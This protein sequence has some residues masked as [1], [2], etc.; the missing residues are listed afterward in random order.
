MDQKNQSEQN[1]RILERLSPMNKSICLECNI[2]FK[3]RNYFNNLYCE[4]C[5]VVMDAKK[6][7]ESRLYEIQRLDKL[8]KQQIPLKYQ[9]LKY[10][11]TPHNL[12]EL[13]N[14]SLFITGAV[15]VGK[16]TLA[17]CI[18]KT[19][20]QKIRDDCNMWVSFPYLIMKLQGMFR[21]DGNPFEYAERIS[22]TEGLLVIDD[23]GAEKMTDYVRQIAYFIINSREQH[24]RQ[25]IITSNYSLD[26][27]DKMIDSRVSSRIAGM[28]EVIKLTGKDR[29]VSK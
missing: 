2:E 6:K 1:T 9:T 18:Y 26:Q 25:T 11:G 20:L 29:R 28:C 24:M 22:W 8:I 23:I 3:D 17:A 19:R 4:K 10:N 15:G 12:N 21:G 14:K 5:S 7:E 16:T 27:I 13:I